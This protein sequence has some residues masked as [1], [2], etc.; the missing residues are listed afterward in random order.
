MPTAIPSQEEI[1]ERVRNGSNIWIAVADGDDERVKLLLEHG[2]VTPVTGDMVQYTPIHAAASYGRHDLLR[3]L[4]RYPGVDKNAVNVRDEDG[5]TPLFFCEDRPT[6][7]LLVTEFGADARLQNDEGITAAQHAEMNEHDDLA[8]YLRSVTGEAAVP[9]S[10]L[11][12]RVGEEEE[13]T[14]LGDDV[15]DADVDNKTDQVM[16]QVQ[17]IME[18]ADAKGE[19]PTEKLREVLGV[20]LARQV[21][22]GYEQAQ[23]DAA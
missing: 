5:D 18:E 6:A 4:L 15:D 17:R 19:D 13:P 3:F 7:E 9:R 1:A 16:E 12:H 20:S 2:G 8:E 10:E 14:D 23:H 22:E 21:L 11:L